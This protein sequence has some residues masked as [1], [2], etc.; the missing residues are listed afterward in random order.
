MKKNRMLRLASVLLVSVLLTTSVISGTFAKYVTTA[1]ASDS[2]RVAKWGITMDVNGTGTFSDTYDSGHVDSADNKDVVAPGTSGSA[3][4][5]VSGTPE[6]A[7]KITFNSVT[8]TMKDVFLAKDLEYSY[9]DADDTNGTVDYTA[10]GGSTT[11]KVDAA[12]YPISYKITVTSA[13]ATFGKVDSSKDN[14]AASGTEKSFN[15][16]EAAMSALSNTVLTYAANQ[17]AGLTVK[18]E[19]EWPFEVT[20][21]KNDVYDTILGDI[22]AQNTD[23]TVDGK[24]GNNI[25]ASSEGKYDT[26]IAFDLAITATQID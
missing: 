7:Y 21:S 9:A 3:T 18:I 13:T 8:G 23:L 10:P 25:T 17:P 24:T 15:N 6:T 4:Y 16:L 11:T 22:I 20:G 14:I 2:A 26:T 1:D 19:W 12:Y 5:S